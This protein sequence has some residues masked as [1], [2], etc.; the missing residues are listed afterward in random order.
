MCIIAAH[1]IFSCIMICKG[2]MKNQHHLE[3]REGWPRMTLLQG[4]QQCRRPTGSRNA[5]DMVDTEGVWCPATP[6]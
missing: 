6:G 1:S 5:P 3:L 4:Q 2:E